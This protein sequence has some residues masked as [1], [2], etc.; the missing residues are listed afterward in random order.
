MINFLFFTVLGYW[1][2]VRKNLGI[3]L[4]ATGLLILLSACGETKIENED[5]IK[6]AL[7]NV[8]AACQDEDIKTLEEVLEVV[9]NNGNGLS[10]NCRNSF[11]QIPSPELKVKFESIE[12]EIDHI[13]VLDWNNTTN[14]IILTAMQNGGASTQ[15]VSEVEAFG[16]DS[17]GNETPLTIDVEDIE[18]NAAVSYIQDYSGSMTDTDIEDASRYQGYFDGILPEGSPRQ[19][20]R[21]NQ[22]VVDVTNGFIQSEIDIENALTEDD[23]FIRGAT[24]LYDS[25][26]KG[27]FDLKARDENIQIVILST[28]GRENSSTEFTRSSLSSLI[29]S[30]SV[31]TIVLA[32]S[33]AD[34]KDLKDILG[35]KGTLIYNYKIRELE[36][37]IQ[38][39]TDSFN[40]PAIINII[41]DISE[42]LEIRIVLNDIE[43][44]IS[45]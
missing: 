22:Q 36:Q 2:I 18:L 13:R 40:D 39:L 21:F 32:S 3:F 9:A 37:Q 44:T 4:S 7:E 12:L 31:Y 26:G 11:A 33:F 6:K 42:Y 20:I 8:K 27:I 30:S 35:N 23:T 16:V 41:D 29:E 25:W 1:L 17:S 19:V 24:A 38:E 10:A 15:L 5:D 34:K 45:L 14:S 28:D 43:S